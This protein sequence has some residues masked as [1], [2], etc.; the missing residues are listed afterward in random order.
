MSREQTF[1]SKII[2]KQGLH[3]NG[4][5]VCILLLSGPGL[6]LKLVRLHFNILCFISTC[7][8]DGKIESNILTNLWGMHFGMSALIYIVLQ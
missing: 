1:Q 7:C 4:L 2:P 3:L 5:S 6:Y 8:I